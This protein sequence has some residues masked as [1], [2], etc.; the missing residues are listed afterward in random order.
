MRPFAIVP[1][2]LFES[3]AAADAKFNDDWRALIKDKYGAKPEIH[4]FETPVVVDNV[5]G[6][7][8]GGAVV[9]N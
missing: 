8:V 1:A 4:F 2:Y 9:E 6:E 3:R 5:A 7:I